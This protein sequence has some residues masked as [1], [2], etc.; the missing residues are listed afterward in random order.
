MER[1][2]AAE[3][4]QNWEPQSPMSRALIIIRN[5]EDRLRAAAWARKAPHG[6]RIEFKEAK[7]SGEQN[8]LMWAM[9]TDV[10]AQKLHHGRTYDAVEWKYI[11]MHALGREVQFIPSLDGK[12]FLPF[13]QSTSDLSRAEMTALIDFIDAW[14]AQNGIKLRQHQE[15][16]E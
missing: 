1:I 7:R 11:F 4:S 14:A 16:A 15:A 2:D 9:L 13:G 5:D 3:G 12:T 6:C 10:A 8:A